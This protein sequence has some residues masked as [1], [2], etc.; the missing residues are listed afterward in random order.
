MPENNDFFNDIEKKTNVSKQQLF[1][2]AD[3]AKHSNFTDEASVRRLIAQV[4]QVA[5]VSVSKEKEDRL[6]KA[7]INN[8]IPTDLSTLAKMFNQSK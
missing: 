4:A 3:T 8:Q 7:I 1:E 2:L 6:V 5:G